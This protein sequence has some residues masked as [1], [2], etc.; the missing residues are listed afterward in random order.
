VVQ[1]VG[2]GQVNTVNVD[3]PLGYSQEYLQ[4]LKEE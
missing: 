2:A 4:I 3:I 1:K